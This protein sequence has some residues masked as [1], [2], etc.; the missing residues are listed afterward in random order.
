MPF[1]IS[2]L[3][4]HLLSK[5]L[6]NIKKYREL[7][8]MTQLELAHAIDHS[9]T[10]IISLGEIGKGKHFNIKQL[11]KISAILNVDICKFFETS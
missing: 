8:S 9:T 11:H 6:K 1:D 10:T 3:S 2:V 7:K 5:M 4:L